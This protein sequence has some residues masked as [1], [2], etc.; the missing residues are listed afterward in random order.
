MDQAPS[1]ELRPVAVPGAGAEPSDRS[2]LRRL[3]G[4][5]ED[6]AMQIY[7]RY[8]HRLRALARDNCP[9]DLA[10]RFDPEDIVQ[11][12]F[13]SFFQAAGRGIYDVPDGEELWKLFLVIALNK[14]RDK[15][16][17]HHAPKRDVRL[18]RGGDALDHA[19]DARGQYDESAYVFL[20]LVV[21]ET[22]APLPG[23]YRQMIELRIEGYE[24]AE[25]ARKVGRSK[26]TVE[27]A[28]QEFRTRLRSALKEEP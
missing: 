5:N 19:L 13:R 18:T 3:R 4:G 1:A 16:A 26:R 2:L 21:E 7:L 24:V 8:A 6:A 23:P 25:I 22:M 17:F 15:G 11:S 14:I 27:R 20:Q 9:A 10:P 12:V 28:L